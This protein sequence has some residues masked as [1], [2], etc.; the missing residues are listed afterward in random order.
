MS[1]Q[2]ATVVAETTAVVE[3][4]TPT[5]VAAAPETPQAPESQEQAPQVEAPPAPTPAEQA[6]VVRLKREKAE[7]ADSL[8]VVTRRYHQVEREAKERDA[9]GKE[10]APKSAS[11]KSID[12]QLA[13]LPKDTDESG[14]DIVKL[15]GEWLS[16]TTAREFLEMRE[17]REQVRKDQAEREHLRAEQDSQERAETR[18]K[19]GE[20]ME[21]GVSRYISVIMRSDFKHVPETHR[22][23]VEAYLASTVDTLIADAVKKAGDLG[24]DPL[25]VL[26]A[27]G[28]LEGL[29]DQAKD[30]VK[31]TLGAFAE[32]QLQSNQRHAEQHKVTTPTGQP[33]VVPAMNYDEYSLLSP[34]EQRKVRARI[35]AIV[36]GGK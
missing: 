30:Q 25:Q 16:P 7:I 1:E 12:D 5:E 29:G 34:A 27:D 19:A 26:M 4:T 14:K 32:A 13:A 24:Q 28:F 6:E 18:R 22:D 31:E 20:D 3:P 36:G 35:A 33:A 21:A 9:K 10:T 15:G 2:T 8:R 23:G 17:T 11:P